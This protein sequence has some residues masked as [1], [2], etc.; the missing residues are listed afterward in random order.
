[1]SMENVTDNVEQRVCDSIREIHAFNVCSY[2]SR[3]TE[4]CQPMT[5]QSGNVEADFE[6]LKLAVKVSC[7]MYH[8]AQYNNTNKVHSEK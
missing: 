7:C 4:F 1:M 3:K 8:S 5:P 2:M 6:T